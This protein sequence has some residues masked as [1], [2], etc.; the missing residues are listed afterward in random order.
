M[1]LGFFGKKC[2]YELDELFQNDL[3]GFFTLKVRGQLKWLLFFNRHVVFWEGIFGFVKQCG[4][5]FNVSDFYS[6]LCPFVPLRLCERI[7]SALLEK[8]KKT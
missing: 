1:A 7:N 3:N 4:P 8:V 5:D 6:T 2:F